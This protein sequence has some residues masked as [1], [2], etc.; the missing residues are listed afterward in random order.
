M[1]LALRSS[2][3]L[4]ER[5]ESLCEWLLRSLL[6]DINALYCR[7]DVLYQIFDFIGQVKGIFNKKIFRK[8]NEISYLPQLGVQYGY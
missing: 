1:A 2:H 4:D 6:A 8:R 3:R 5:S 7:I